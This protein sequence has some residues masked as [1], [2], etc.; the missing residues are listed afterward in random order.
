MQRTLAVPGL[1][2]HQRPDFHRPR[3]PPGPQHA[4]EAEDRVE[5]LLPIEELAP[6]GA[7]A[8]PGPHPH[9]AFGGGSA[10]ARAA[11]GRRPGC[12]HSAMPATLV[13][14]LPGR[15]ASGRRLAVGPGRGR[16]RLYAAAV[17]GGC[18]G[19]DAAWSPHDTGTPSA[20]PRHRHRAPVTCRRD[21]VGVR[22]PGGG[23]GCAA[24][25]RW[26]P[27]GWRCRRADA[28]AAPSQDVVGDEIVDANHSWLHTALV[29]VAPAPTLMV[30][31]IPLLATNTPC[32]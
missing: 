30:P 5:S 10:R 16:T 9:A 21:R 7:R 14:P 11:A 29:A 6:P 24:R 13:P 4:R 19:V 8:P 22:S 28:A 20:R 25:V 3:L 1:C 18:A 31:V 27:D 23:T 17:N 26:R 12:G 32:P 2:R 15:S